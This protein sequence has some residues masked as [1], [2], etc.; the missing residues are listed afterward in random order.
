MRAFQKLRF[1]RQSLL[2]KQEADGELSDEFQFHLQCQ[3]DETSL[4]EWTRRKPAMPLCDRCCVF[5]IVDRMRKG[6][7]SDAGKVLLLRASQDDQGPALSECEPTQRR[8]TLVR[9]TVLPE[10]ARSGLHR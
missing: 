7:Q 8:P 1:R 5:C 6:R 3:I 4:K 2:R 9:L 10:P